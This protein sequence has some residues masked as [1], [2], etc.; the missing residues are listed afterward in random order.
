MNYLQCGTGFFRSLVAVAGFGL[1]LATA[2]HAFAK[3]EPTKSTNQTASVIAHVLLPGTPGTEMLLQQHGDK[4]YLYIVRNSKRGFTVVDVTDP[5]KPEVLKQVAW[6]NG[7][8]SGQLQLVGSRLGIAEAADDS[9][10]TANATAATETINLLDLANPSNPRT[11][12]TFTGVTSVLAE[13]GRHLIYLTNGEGLWIVRQNRKQQLPACSS[14]D[15]I[16]SMPT[17]N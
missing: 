9:S 8:R 14:A 10:T 5:G 7:A 3:H 13:P 11:I 12:Q 1:L 6:P 16:S 17:C 4:Q 2:P 15:A